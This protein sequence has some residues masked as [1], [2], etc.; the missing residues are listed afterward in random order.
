MKRKNILFRNSLHLALLGPVLALGAPGMAIA[1]NASSD[2][3]QDENLPAGEQGDP[4]ELD[5]IVAIG[6]MPASTVV[7]GSEVDTPDNRRV[8]DVLKGMPNIL[9]NSGGKGLPTMRGIDGSAAS[10]FG[11]NQ[12]TA[13]RPR[14]NTLVDGVARPY[15]GAHPLS[16]SSQ[17]GLW[18]VETVE[19]AR[20]PQTTTTGRS[21]LTGAVN[22]STRDPVH[23]WEAAAR[24][25]WFNEPGT[26]EGAAMVNLPLVKDQVALRFAF[27]GSDG[28]NHVDFSNAVDWPNKN[29]VDENYVD[30]LEEE[31]YGHYRGKLLLTPKFLPDTELVF[32]I[33][34]TRAKATGVPSVEDW[35]ADDPVAK[36]TYYLPYEKE[37]TVYS[38]KLLQGLGEK[39]DLEVRVSYLDNT[40]KN[41]QTEHLAVSKYFFETETTSVEALLHFEELGLMDK[42]MVGVAYEYEED[43]AWNDGLN[44][45]SNGDDWYHVTS[46]DK[47]N[48]AIFGEIEAGIGGGWTAIAGGRYEWDERRRDI[49]R[50][51]H[52]PAF[53]VVNWGP[54]RAEGKVS[55][56]AFSPKLGIRY[57]GADKYVAG[58]TYSEGYRP[59]GVDFWHFKQTLPATIFDDERLKNHEIWVRGNPLGRL[60]LDGSVFYYE[61]E[62]MQLRIYDPDASGVLQARLFDGFPTQMGNIPEAKGYG[63]E[64][65]GQFRIDDAWT[66]S[67]GLG[68]LKTEVT[69]AGDVPE[70]DGREL[71][72][73]PNLTWNLG[74]GWV[75]PHGFDAE[76]SAR[77]VGGFQQSH[78]IYDGTNGRYY[79]ETAS[80]TLFDFK[81]GYETKFRG[82]EL[83]ID[84]WVENLTDKRYKLSDW[85]PTSDKP[86]RPRTIG[87][88]VTARF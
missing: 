6:R 50:I 36:K 49:Y 87:I 55:D 38:A 42:G 8:Q 41:F 79:D 18:D 14:V 31:E 58:Y 33:N 13:N 61:F 84:A 32:N 67:G 27:E 51:M 39:M 70:Y 43:D 2:T 86:G 62:D 10:H 71:S 12:H 46:G 66:I 68:L 28:E 60:R 44:W 4:I 63:M 76:I 78:V 85:S 52:E 64:L 30:E 82:T 23:E 20:G 74:L 5:P 80:Y 1:D 17:S 77:H 24:T 15:K 48:F 26:V 59:G 34:E 7:L 35:R 19:V 37:Q 65:D 25:G 16:A 40:F 57:D 75:S 83:R 73:S 29:P 45:N 72:Q 56:E 9:D 81:A 22:V 53:G 3:Q 11:E 47:E 69:D 54:D 21:S 88:A